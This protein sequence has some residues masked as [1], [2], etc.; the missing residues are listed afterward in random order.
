MLALTDE[1]RDA[2]AAGK[3]V[4]ALESTIISHGMPYPRNAETAV[5]AEKLARTPVIVVSAGAKA[6]L[7]LPRTLEYLETLGVPVL[8]YRTDEFPAFYCRESGLPRRNLSDVPVPAQPRAASGLA[9]GQSHTG[10][11]CPSGHR[12]RGVCRPG[13]A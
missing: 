2:L 12:G 11:V 9:R 7:D 13:S 4:I 6:I 1:V 3:P 5:E 10:A 8:G